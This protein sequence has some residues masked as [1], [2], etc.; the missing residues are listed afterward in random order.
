[1]SPSRT[2]R[3]RDEVGVEGP[4]ILDRPIE[5]LE[6]SIGF[7]GEELERENRATSVL[8]PWRT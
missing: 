7:G 8:P 1:M 6:A 4:E 2:A 3:Y 5:G